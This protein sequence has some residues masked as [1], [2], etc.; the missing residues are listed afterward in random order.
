MTLFEENLT[1]PMEKIGN[2]KELLESFRGYLLSGGENFTSLGD[3]LNSTEDISKVTEEGEPLLVG[4]YK[5][6]KPVVVD[7]SEYTSAVI[8]G[9]SGSGKSWLAYSLMMGLF[10]TNDYED[11]AVGILDVKANPIWDAFAEY[12]HV[13]KHSTDSLE[14]VEVLRGLLNEQQERQKLLN[15]LNLADIQEYHK[16]VRESG[17]KNEMPQILVVVDEITAV[18]VEL[19]NT[20]EELHEEFVGLLGEITQK[21]RSAGIHLLVVG[22]RASERSIPKAVLANSSLKIALKLTD[23]EEYETLL[24]A[25]VK[26]QPKPERA[27]EGLVTSDVLDHLQTLKFLTVGGEDTYQ[28]LEI[29]KAVGNDWKI[30]K[31]ARI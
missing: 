6:G 1:V 9:G 22:Q 28:L 21:G 11:L 10:T 3:V 15:D 8:V 2:R 18:M 27:G 23:E 12:P 17:G 26:E 7:L 25:E 20:N 4:L 13:V 14:Y 5:E 30:R 19:E 29:V 31:D 16:V 24:G